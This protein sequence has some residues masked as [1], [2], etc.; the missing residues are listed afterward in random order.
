MNSLHY[1]SLAGL[2]VFTIILNLPF[3]FFRSKVE[4][5]SFRWFLYIHLPIPLIYVLRRILL[6]KPVIIPLL[7]AAAVAGQIF[8]GRLN[9]KQAGDVDGL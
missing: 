2:A 4:K 3:G 5:Y 1:L 7:I 6:F 9:R 8:G